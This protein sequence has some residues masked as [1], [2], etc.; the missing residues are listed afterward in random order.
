MR[1]SDVRDRV[2][3][4][5]AGILQAA[6]NRFD[7]A[8]GLSGGWDSRVLLA[9][10]R[11]IADR[12]SIYNGRGANMPA[13][14][15]D[16]VIPRRLADRFGLRLD[17]IAEGHDLD[18]DFA[19]H[20]DRHSWM[21]HVHF[22]TG[23][24]AD[25]E[26]YHRGKV[27]VIGNVSEIGKLPYRGKLATGRPIDGRFL[28]NFYWG[29]HDFA[30]SALDEWL[31][32]VGDGRGFNLLDLFY[33]EQRLGRWLAANCVEFDFAWRE[34]LAPFNI[35]GLMVDLLACDEEARSPPQ[36]R[37]YRLLIESHWP[38]L[39]AEPINP[40]PKIP[41]SRRIKASARR[42]LKAI[43]TRLRPPS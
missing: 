37:L 27:A 5:L 4:R 6:D 43:R 18:P 9:A 21:P 20:F 1:I 23:M 36:H 17:P 2:G 7:L 30:A 22:A 14:H 13:T 42:G 12:L 35:R 29:G 38:E 28:A 34:V 19:A 32:D 26:C 10:A 11:P 31:A 24:Q 40:S 16:V 3:G 41:F 39:L 15:H 8:L 25:F 33:W